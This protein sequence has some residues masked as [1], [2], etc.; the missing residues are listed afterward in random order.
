VQ[1]T[2]YAMDVADAFG[3]ECL[4]I[5]PGRLEG[6]SVE[7]AH[8]V[9][10]RSLTEVFELRPDSDVRL[11]LEPVIDMQSDY[12]NSIDR[13]LDLIARVDHERLGV[14]PDN[15]HLWINSGWESAAVLEQI[16]RA[17]GRIF[18]VH[19][20]DA[21][22]GSDARYVPGD[23]ELPLIE[24]DPEEYGPD[25]VIPRCRAGF[26]KTVAGALAGV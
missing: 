14:Y 22:R 26:D 17:S 13:T 7:R 23:G 8:N 4:V 20:N 5:A 24:S 15:Y 9:A 3:A 2:A 16:E 10:A 21:V 11:A 19:V 25:A 12:M 6:R 18:G 1:Y